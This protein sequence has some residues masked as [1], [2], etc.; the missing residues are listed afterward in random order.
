LLGEAGGGRPI[1]DPTAYGFSFG[2]CFIWNPVTVAGGDGATFPDSQL[3]FNHFTD[4]TS[5]ILLV[6]DVKAWTP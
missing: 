3:E 2:E 5:S 1:L 4:R 6:S